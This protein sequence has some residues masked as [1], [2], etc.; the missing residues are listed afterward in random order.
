MNDKKN[1][2]SSYYITTKCVCTQGV[3]ERPKPL[4]QVSQ[5]VCSIKELIP[6]SWKPFTY[7]CNV[8]FYSGVLPIQSKLPT[9]YQYVRVG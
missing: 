2:R 7:I 1:V 4:S 8:S 9:S 5:C 3:Y 6:L